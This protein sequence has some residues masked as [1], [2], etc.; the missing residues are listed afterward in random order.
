[1]QG[2]LVRNSEKPLFPLYVTEWRARGYGLGG[3]RYEDSEINATIYS[4]ECFL[5]LNQNNCHLL[6]RTQM[7][8]SRLSC[9]AYWIELEKNLY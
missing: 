2:A 8:E 5:F 4:N 3:R 9:L 7:I 1:M 6:S